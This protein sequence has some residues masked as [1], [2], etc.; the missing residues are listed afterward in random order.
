MIPWE[1]HFH[2]FSVLVLF[3][4]VQGTYRLHIGD[5]FKLVYLIWQKKIRIFFSIWY[6]KL[7][8]WL[9]SKSLDIIFCWLDFQVCTPVVRGFRD[10]LVIINLFLSFWDFSNLYFYQINRKLLKLGEFILLK[11]YL[12]LLLW[13]NHAET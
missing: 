13:Y 9:N 4:L 10:K 11:G 12:T 8:L 3:C 2:L 6:L 7:F 1:E 5:E